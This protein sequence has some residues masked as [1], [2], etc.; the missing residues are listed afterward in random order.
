M[1]AP[2]LRL[3]RIQVS[4][5]LSVSPPAFVSNAPSHGDRSPHATQEPGA[6]GKGTHSSSPHHR[7]T[8]PEHRTSIW[9]LPMTYRVSPQLLP[10]WQ[11]LL[12]S[13]QVPGNCKGRKASVSNRYPS[14]DTPLTT[15]LGHASLLYTAVAK[16]LKSAAH[17]HEGNSVTT[18][19]ILPYLEG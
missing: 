18:T 10:K 19:L 14:S 16:W 7:I 13:A 2:S 12:T 11:A 9:G 15:W 5:D 1:P 4:W 8:H 17:A 3:A 6:H